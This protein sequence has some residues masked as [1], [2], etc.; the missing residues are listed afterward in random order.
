MEGQAL[1]VH[2][3]KVKFSALGEVQGGDSKFLLCLADRGLK[4]GLTGF[5]S[6]AGS[7]DLTR[8][9]PPLLPDHQDQPPLPHKT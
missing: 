8:T 2:E 4:C 6:S 3:L 1:P 7:V 5:E 9:K